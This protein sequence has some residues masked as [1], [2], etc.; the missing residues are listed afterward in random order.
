MNAPIMTPFDL[1][2]QGITVSEI[3]RNLSPSKLYEHA[4]RHEKDA[5]IAENGAL[6][7]YSGLKTGRSPKDK[8]VVKNAASENDIWWGAVNIPLDP[9]TF[10]I[11]RQRAQDYLNTRERLYCFDGFAG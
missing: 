8:R 4:I 6:V 3:H 10:D 1:S 5:S 2:G 7:A 9:R 11:N